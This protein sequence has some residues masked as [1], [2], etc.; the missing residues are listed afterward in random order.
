MNP[1]VHPA[2]TLLSEQPVSAMN[3]WVEEYQHIKTG[4]QHIHI[5]ADNPENVFLVALRTVPKDSTG[6]AHILEHTALCG[7]QRYPVRDP[8][9]MMTRRSLNTFM[10]AFTSSDW[11][12][13]PF[14][15]INRKDFS[16]LLGVY[17]DAVFFSRLDPLD[18][19]QEGHR[20]E[21]SE[22][23][24]PTSDL[25]Y[26]GVVYNEMKGA[27][28]SVPSQLWQTLTKYLFPTTTYHH[29]SG[30]DPEAIT[31]LTYEQLV[32]FYRTHYHPSNAIF[33]TYGDIPAVEHQAKFEELAL[34]HF[35]RSDHLI[36]VP[37]E[38]RY[39]APVKVEEYY[40]LNEDD[41]SEKTH[42]VLAW[43]LGQSTN[44]EDV[45]VGHLLS[46][47]LLNNSACPL[48]QALETTDLGQSPSPLCGMDDSQ[49][50][51][52]FICGLEGAGKENIEAIENFILQTLEQIAVDG[53]PAEDAEAA[54]H[55]LE[56]HQREVGGDHHP[57]GLQII[58][59]ALTAATHRGDPVALLNI[60]PALSQLREQIKDPAFLQAR[61]RRLLLD[62]PHRVRLALCPDA[63]L[64]ERKQAAELAQLARIQA[65]LSADEKQAIIEQAEALAQRQG[66]I[67]DESILPKVTLDDVPLKEGHL[68]PSVQSLHS[69]NDL[70]R[71]DVGTN[72]LVYQQIVLDLPQLSES[73]VHLL[74]YYTSL[75]TEVGVGELD[76]IAMQRKQAATTGGFSAYT[77]IRGT[78][79]DVH[80]TQNFLT[81]SGKALN[82]NQ[83]GLSELM[84]ATLD[85][86]R[87]NELNRIRESIAQARAHREQ[88]ITN[89]G[90]GL[91]MTAATQGM[92]AIARLNH[93]LGGLASIQRLKQLDDSLDNETALTAFCKSLSSIHTAVKDAPRRY[94]WVGEEQQADTQLNALKA[95]FQPAQ[96]SDFQPFSLA[97]Y[98][99]QIKQAWLTNSQVHFCAKAYAT[100][101]MDHEDSA[102]L[103]VLGNILRNGFLHRVIREQGGAYGG[104]ASQ[105]SNS[106]AFRFFSY[107]DPRMEET[108]ADFDKAIDWFMHTQ[109]SWQSIEE[110]I[111]GAV[112]GIDKPDSPA[113]RA[114]RLFHA[115][116]HGRTLALR[117]AFR[118]RLL[119]TKLPDLQRVCERYL[120]PELA[121]TAIVTDKTHAARAE[122]LGLELH[123]V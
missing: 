68:T 46:G 34:S 95:A 86:A 99:A 115:D 107:R 75:L 24:N 31:D 47:V 51:L 14:A 111:L 93:D 39:F 57:F 110:S 62:N 88:S 53:I 12:A 8:F 82:R 54:L 13:Y 6:V 21:F 89:N 113:G 33:M 22:T 28:S 38:K 4:A 76:Y 103:V 96:P 30:G 100:V 9:F 108:L 48:M 102:P 3:I 11:T 77:S 109:H 63:Q 58:L 44:L 104:G 85:G 123:W 67:D 25:V 35:E 118:D 70:F 45:L 79:D 10:N 97:P 122:A 83:A 78:V 105:D 71:Y 23:G 84:Q 106:G 65:A 69:P 43:L 80:K 66:R 74:P 5:R 61:I 27:M 81:L 87:F 92:C 16:N 64:S 15:S 91:A 2:F 7:S 117:Q 41:L 112:S 94:L 56:L 18:F 98:Q 50:E 49:K 17:L 119:A 19:A 42:V 37:D 101:P 55:Q 29:N 1:A 32:S 20:L 52:T 26:K 120:K 60:D 121:N 116:L 72:G 114:K 90:H 36:Q 73:L 40:P 59:N